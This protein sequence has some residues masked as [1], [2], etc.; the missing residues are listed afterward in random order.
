MDLIRFGRGIRALR[1][2]RKWR[3]QDL[4][5]ESR[6]SR[7][8]I[9]RIE[10]GR[11]EDIPVR[12]LTKVAAMLGART[13]LRLN[14][15]GEA[16]DRL[17]DADHARLVDLVAALLRATGWEVAIEVTFWIRGERGSIDILAWHPRERIVLVV[18]VKTVVPDQQ[19]MLA[20][21]D[22]KSRL[23]LEIARER[24]WQGVAVGRLLV[25]RTSRTTRRRVAA[26]AET[27]ASTFTHR[28]R[29][30]RAWL[31]APVASKPFAG[32]L[33][34]SDVHATNTRHRVSRRGQTS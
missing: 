14:W 26:H 20:T 27:Y 33:F 1:H 19:S 31:A 6:L 3:Q 32:L 4:A 29:G 21:L 18:E 16:L 9:A 11:S 5:N 25:M 28:T 34:V 22:R 15:N 2:R 8:K 24:G 23:G 13:E 12:D 10:L 30:A 17:L 7:T